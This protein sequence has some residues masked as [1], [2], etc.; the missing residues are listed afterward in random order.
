MQTIRTH[1][2][3]FVL[4]VLLASPIYG[5]EKKEPAQ[6]DVVVPAQTET[7]LP[8]IDL[9]EF[10]I[11]G[12]ETIDLPVSSKTIVE[13]EKVYVPG[14][15]SPGSKDAQFD[16]GPKQLKE[17]AGPAGQMNGKVLAGIGAYTTPFMEGWFGKNYEE[18]GILFHAGY[19]SSNGHVANANWQKTGVGLQGDYRSPQTSGVLAESRLSGGLNFSGQSYRAYGSTTPSQLRTLDDM[20]LE[21]GLTPAPATM[22]FF[23]NPIDYSGSLSWNGT[24]LDDSSNASENDLGVTISG[25]TEKGGARFRGTMDYVASGVSMR[26]PPNIA[27]HSPQWFALR[28]SAQQ[29]IVPQLQG[30]LTLQ[31]F[32]YRG[33][34][35]V[36]GGRFYPALDLRYF[37]NDALNLFLSFSPSVE[38]N[39]LLTVVAA[40]RYVRNGM[41]L[42]PTEMPASV[43]IGS[44]VL[45]NEKL[46]AKGTLSYRSF[47]DYPVFVELTSAKVWDVM[48][49]QKASAVQF[50]LEGSYH[51]SSSNSAWLSASL[52]STK[53]EG[54][55]NQVPNLPAFSVSGVYRQALQNGVDLEGHVRYS[56]QRWTTISHTSAN[57]GYIDVGGK[58]EYQVTEDLRAVLELDNLMNQRYYLWDGYVERPFFVSLGVSYKW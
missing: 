37:L 1:G 46:R 55:A 49:L 25:T 32:I 50:D 23:D 41:D 44:E 8:K 28:F 42:R 53:A 34:L 9:P 31:Q 39:T 29:M 24:S 47:R 43:E 40:D 10:L 5:Q 6:R 21:L 14:S 22:V 19:E 58:G 27:G 48:Y 18:G 35:S 7:P 30:T 11:T 54:S 45:V 33:N 16:E 26:Y 13:E 2:V 52:N 17:I 15:L 12:Q 56:S 57:A 3:V 51:L 20:R 38:Q 4:L 36:T